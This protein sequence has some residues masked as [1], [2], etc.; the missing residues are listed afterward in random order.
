MSNVKWRHVFKSFTWFSPDQEK[1][2]ISLWKLMFGKWIIS[3]QCNDGL[4]V[5]TAALFQKSQRMMDTP[6]WVSLTLLGVM[7]GSMVE[8]KRYDT[9]QG[10][11]SQ[12]ASLQADL[13]QNYFLWESFLK[14]GSGW[15]QAVVNLCNNKQQKFM[16]LL[17]LHAP[18]CHLWY[19]TIWL[20]FSSYTKHI[21]HIMILSSKPT[22]ATSWDAQAHRGG[23]CPLDTDDGQ[24]WH[25][26]HILCTVCIVTHC[27]TLN[28]N[29]AEWQL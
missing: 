1:E 10:S 6:L 7:L 5:I 21:F 19:S 27:N 13:I 15:K 12:R 2:T 25:S 14:L 11:T 29:R 16:F 18:N 17:Y 20:I 28:R 24:Q 3:H 4:V 9:M 23:Q 22:S 8:V 26:A